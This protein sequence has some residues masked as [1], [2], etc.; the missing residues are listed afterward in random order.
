MKLWTYSVRETCRH[1]GRALLTLLGI[2]LGLAAIVA[3]RLTI[4]TVHRAYG[5]LRSRTCGPRSLE[6]TAAGQAGFAGSICPALAAVP[7]VSAVLPRIGGTVA[8]LGKSSSVPVGVLG[9]DP[10]TDRARTGYSLQEG[11]FLGAE[12]EGLL[13]ADLARLLG[14]ATGES[15]SLWTPGGTAEVRIAGI[16]RPERI[17]KQLG[18]VLIVSIE[19][20]RRLLVLPGRINSLELLVADD[21]DISRVQQQISDR[22]PAGLT[23]HAPQRAVEFARNS[24][25]ASEQGLTLLG[26][27]AVIAAGFVI[28]NTFLLN[29]GE[30]RHQLAVLRTLGA[31]GSQV[32][33]LVLQEAALYG[34]TG[35]LAGCVVGW[36]LAFLLLRVMGQ[37]LKVQLP[38]LE[39]TDGP[40]LLVLILGP[41]LAVAA[42]WFPARQASRQ[43]PLDELRQRQGSQSSSPP[44][45]GFLPGVLL[46]AIGIALEFGLCQG[47][48]SAGLEKLLSVPALGLCMVGSVLV[49]PRV[50][51]PLLRLSTFLP[52]GLE[53]TIAL[54]QL[55]R[56]PTRTGLTATVLFLALAVAIG[57]GQAVRGIAGDLGRWCRQTIVADYLVRG[58]MPD[59]TFSLSTALPE[60]LGDDLAS[61]AHVATVERL[62]FVPA[63]VNGTP[64]LVLARTFAG[65]RPLP[66]DLHEGQPEAV[67]RGL[68]EGEVVLGLPLSRELS[69]HAGDSLTL[70]TLEGPRTLRIAGTATEYAGGGKALYL[71]WASARK[72]LGL[73]GVHAFLV[74]ARPGE[75]AELASPLQSFCDQHQ[76]Q[77][78][79]T[80][81]LHAMIEQQASRITGVLWGLMA[82]AFLVASLALIN[83]L[84]LTVAE[85]KVEF[86]I[87]RALGLKRGQLSRV[88]LFQ[89][90]FLAGVTL[91]PGAL[92]GTV[93]AFL[94]SSSRG[95]DAPSA[96]FHFDTVMLLGPCLLAL[97]VALLAALGPARHIA[98]M[99]VIQ[100][101]R[102]S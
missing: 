79:V 2:T 74:S 61:C 66:L 62:A 46:L 55:T 99:P 67:R 60:V 56:H 102:Q 93:L 19:D 53:G 14:I 71:E 13:D 94:I 89:A 80:G 11:T 91:V 7:G 24:L 15:L 40:F 12:N 59:L 49:F 68:A 25:V 72:Y 44:W 87:L 5:D 92:A 65:D 18:G 96:G 1:P 28:T 45:R 70:T 63:E 6:V 23:V 32:T 51:G 29:L 4:D 90:V 9:I 98:R 37:F 82:L 57:F 86:G 31:T 69:L 73:S 30:R 10:D 42:A 26:L 78:Q 27:V 95:L 52:V 88:V 77:L 64:V 84:T 41:I 48:F 50:V 39:L 3:T 38:G 35:A 97:V 101:T 83:T 20:A 76:L 17:G 16:V 36:A 100:A 54:R 34:L 22:L 85:E 21:S 75:A 47:W 58:S 43:H 33:R 8:A 81:E